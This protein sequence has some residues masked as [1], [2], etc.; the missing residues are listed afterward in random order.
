[1]IQLATSIVWMFCSVMMSPDSSREEPPARSTALGVARPGMLGLV[2]EWVL[3]VIGGFTEHEPSDGAG[4]HATQ[5]L[6]EE[7]VRP[8][9]EV[10]QEAQAV[11]RRLGR[12]LLDRLAAGHVDRDGL[13]EVDVLSGSDGIRCLGRMEEG[14]ALDG[15]RVEFLLEQA[16]VA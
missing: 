11:G 4:M 1:M 12:A 16:P 8:G 13:G 6:D 2:L 9:L 3:G 7:L 5:G 14:R 15:D 10:H